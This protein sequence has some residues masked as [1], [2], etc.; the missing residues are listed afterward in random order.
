[1]GRLYRSNQEGEYVVS[2]SSRIAYRPDAPFPYRYRG[3][4]SISRPRSNSRSRSTRS[5]SSVYV[6]GRGRGG[7]VHAVSTGG[8]MATCDFG[9]GSLFWS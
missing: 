4:W 5:L 8:E 9:R 2:V 6:D 3:L 7:R 1:M